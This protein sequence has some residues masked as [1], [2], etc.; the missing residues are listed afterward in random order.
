MPVRALV[1]GEKGL[2]EDLHTYRSTASRRISPRSV[3]SAVKLSEWQCWCPSKNTPTLGCRGH[4]V[5]LITNGVLGPE[6]GF[7]TPEPP[8][9]PPTGRVTTIPPASLQAR[10]E[11]RPEGGRTRMT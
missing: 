3:I 7:G 1:S 2:L 11:Q 10:N 4:G 5:S 9:E 6:V 8:G